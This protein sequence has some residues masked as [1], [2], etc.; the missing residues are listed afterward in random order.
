[1]PSPKYFFALFGEPD[2]PEKDFIESGVYHLHPNAAPSPAEPGDILLLYCS[3]R[4]PECEMTVPGIGIVLNSESKVVRYRYLPFTRPV[5][6]NTLDEAFDAEDLANL[7]NIRFFQF[8]LF[9]ISRE[10]FVRS[11]GEQRI[12]WP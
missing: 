9:E 5:P 6:R 7:H 3:G 2:P 1:M 11:V 12:D 8:W 10:S 4:Y